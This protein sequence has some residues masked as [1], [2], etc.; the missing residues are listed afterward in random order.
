MD[1]VSLRRI[2]V[3]LFLLLI[4]AL[5]ALF[6]MSVPG[7]AGAVERD[8]GARFRY[9]TKDSLIQIE[10]SG[11]RDEWIVVRHDRSRF[12]ERG[13]EDYGVIARVK[14]SQDRVKRAGPVELN[15]DGGMEYIAI[16]EMDGSGPYFQVQIIE[17]LPHGFISSDFS[18]F[19]RPK[20]FR[21]GRIA[22]GVGRYEGART[23]IRYESFR[24]RG[25]QL[26]P[27]EKKGKAGE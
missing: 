10:G 7:E 12:E 3:N 20:I 27:E 6:N 18:S 2:E 17:L 26:I 14:I 8:D 11:P 5:S 9:E 15:G 23:K 21:D 25:G 4:L 24:Y 13:P 19:G 1:V 22:L 16:S